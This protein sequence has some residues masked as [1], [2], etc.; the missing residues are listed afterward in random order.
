MQNGNG[1]GSFFQIIVS[2]DGST[3]YGYNLATTTWYQLSTSNT[4]ST[5][6][7]S[8]PPSA[9]VSG[10][11]VPFI[12]GANCCSNTSDLPW[13]GWRGRIP[14]YDDNGS[15]FGVDAYWIPGV[16]P[17]GGQLPGDIS[18]AMAGWPERHLRRPERAAL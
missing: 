9:I 13:T 4:S 2:A 16:N 6:L 1:V 18:Y 10:T 14:D 3:L 12:L 11:G 8:A 15:G 5:A 7:A 17:G